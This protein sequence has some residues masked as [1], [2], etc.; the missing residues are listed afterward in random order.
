MQYGYSGFVFLCRASLATS[1]SSNAAHDSFVNFVQPRCRH[2]AV[3]QTLETK[4][5]QKLPNEVKDTHQEQTNAADDLCQGFYEVKLLEKPILKHE[6]RTYG[7]GRRAG[8]QDPSSPWGMHRA[9]S[10]PSR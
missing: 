9:G 4:A 8:D 5:T 7:R 1:D 10:S 2:N 3:Q 6:A